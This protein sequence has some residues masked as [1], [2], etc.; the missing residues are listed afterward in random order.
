MITQINFVPF[1]DV[2]LVLLVIF[3]MTASFM[4]TEGGL[5]MRLP[6]MAS[7]EARDQQPDGVVVTIL[8][9]GR[10]YVDDEATEPGDLVRQLASTAEA[11]R[12]RL[13][14]IRADRLVPYERVAHAIDAAKLAGLNDLALATELDLAG[15]QPAVR[16]D[17]D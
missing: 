17:S 4:G 7:A 12:T 13:A 6:R 15:E 8:R 14:I 1:T 5:D 11:K 2:V 3:M 9:S 10:V 16:S